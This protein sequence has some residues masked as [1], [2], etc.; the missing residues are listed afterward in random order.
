[1]LAGDG[2]NLRAPL[3]SA[4][5]LVDYF[6]DAES[7]ACFVASDVERFGYRHLFARDRIFCS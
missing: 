4:V 3:W 6:A 7:E 5:G 2:S 1:M